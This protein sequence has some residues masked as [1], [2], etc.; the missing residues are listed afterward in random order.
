MRQT[1]QLNKKIETAQNIFEQA[2]FKFLENSS[3]ENETAYLC[4]SESYEKLLHEM[5]HPTI[6]KNVSLQKQKR[7]AKEYDFLPT[8]SI[9]SY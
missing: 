8:Q 5:L 2:F 1:N 7:I 4:S 6:E 9:L 3:P